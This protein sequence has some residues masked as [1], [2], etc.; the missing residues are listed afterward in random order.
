MSIDKEDKEEITMTDVT[1]VTIEDET[2]GKTPQK[3]EVEKKEPKVS[4]EVLNNVKQLT[5][6]FVVGEDKQEDLI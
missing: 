6:V 5:D 4:E 1:N 3:V 2:E